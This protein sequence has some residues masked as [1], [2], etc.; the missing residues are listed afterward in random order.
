MRVIELN[1]EGWRD[2]LDYYA[3]LKAALGSPHW[4]GSSPDAWIDSIIYGQINK[5]EA[6]YVIRITGTATCL[7]SL[8]DEI[9]LLRDCIREAREE[10]LQNYGVD[11]DASFEILP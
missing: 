3:A 11:V 2:V 10:K 5:I 6:P 1:A 7:P 4:H 9:L 8:M